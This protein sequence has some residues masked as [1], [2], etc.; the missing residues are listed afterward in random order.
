MIDDLQILSDHIV[1]PNQNTSDFLMEERRS[2]L[3]LF[4]LIVLTISFILKGIYMQ[5]QIRN[6]SSYSER[7]RLELNILKPTFDALRQNPISGEGQYEEQ[8]AESRIYRGLNVGL[9]IKRMYCS[10]ISLWFRL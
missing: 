3:S 4:I 5:L 10:G 1:Y 7:A 8:F 6:N 9:H 2:Y